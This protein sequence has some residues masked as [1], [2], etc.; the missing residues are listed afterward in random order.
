MIAHLVWFA[1]TYGGMME[2]GLRGDLSPPKGFR[3]QGLSGG[4][5]VESYMQWRPSI[6]GRSWVQTFFPL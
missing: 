4:G 2:R 1:E 3:T 6:A 5:R